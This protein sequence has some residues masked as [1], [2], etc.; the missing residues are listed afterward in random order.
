MRV[1]L[2][3]VIAPA[4][5]PSIAQAQAHDDPCACSAS[6]P[7]FM[8]RAALTGDWGGHRTWLEDHGFTISPSYAAEVSI[9][10]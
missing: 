2:L 7:G 6:K 8:R 9:E 10:R 4:V 3:V 1:A 5:A